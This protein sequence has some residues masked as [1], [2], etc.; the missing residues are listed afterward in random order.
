[1]KKLL[2][3]QET[4][5]IKKDFM[6]IWSEKNVRI[7]LILTPVLI[8]IVI[9][10]AFLLMAMLSP[11]EI[12]GAEYEALRSFL[13]DNL[14]SYH[15]RQALFFVAMDQVLPPLFLLIPILTGAMASSVLFAGE[16]ER[17][18]MET[19]LLSPLPA[20]TVGRIKW[21]NSTGISVL[22]TAA[23]FLLMTIIGAVGDIILNVRFFLDG[24]WMITVFI[25]VPLLTAASVLATAFSAKKYRRQREAYKIC[26]FLTLPLI[27]F[28][29]LP[30]TGIYQISWLA[31]LLFSGA[32]LVADICLIRICEKDFTIEK[33]M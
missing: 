29:L 10:L 9:P 26:A 7:V 24:S 21:M 3:H 22:I 2:N 15:V 12:R 28:Y 13:P 11:E 14:A 27:L 5:L 4:S 17:G 19:L 33:M 8:A 16:R 18:T 6:E 1:M 25:L 20:K 31:L 23:S 32:V 30:F